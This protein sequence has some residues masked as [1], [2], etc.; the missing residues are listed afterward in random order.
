MLNSIQFIDTD[1]K[2]DEAI[3]TIQRWV[4]MGVDTETTGLDPYTSELLLLQI[5]DTENQFVFSPHKLSERIIR[6]LK[7]ILEDPN[8][9]KILHNAKFD[10]T[11]LKEKLDI[12]LSNVADTMIAEQLCRAGQDVKYG[13]DKLVD[14]YMWVDMVKTTRKYFIEKKDFEFSEEEIEYAGKDV[15]YLLPL[16]AYI[17]EIIKKKNLQKLEKLENETTLVAGDMELNGLIL[18]PVKWFALEEMAA[19]EADDLKKELNVYFEP[20]CDLSELNYNSPKQ[21]SP[22]LSKIVGKEFGST[23]KKALLN[24]E[25]E[26]VRLLLKYRE[27]FK[28]VSTYGMEFIKKYTNPI[29]KRIHPDY[30]QLRARTGRFSSD[31]PNAQNIP[32]EAKY[33][34]CFVAPKNWKVITADYKSIE[35]VIL[36]ELSQEPKFVEALEKNRDLHRMVASVLY[37]KKEEHITKDERSKGKALSFGVIYGSTAYGLASR[38]NIGRNEAQALLDTFFLKFKKVDRLLRDYVEESFENGY[39]YSPLDGR[40]NSLSTMD[41]DY[42]REMKHAMNVARNQPFQGCCASILKKAMCDIRREILSQDLRLSINASVHDELVFYTHKNEAEENKAL[43]EDSMVKA[44]EYYIKNMP[45]RVD[46]GLGDHW[47]KD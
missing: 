2:A 35:L 6:S 5:G 25:H 41:L 42:P 16:Y 18:D 33:R 8:R 40:R 47:I 4:R 9:T 32:H 37:N 39:A 3:Q 22:L 27:A 7:I 19:K 44:G 10:Y 24:E 26:A 15:G 31:N 11:F 1:E 23:G 21:I 14:K 13:L 36:A 28:L 46:V 38:L 30:N 12:T 34:A 43:V 20:F 29:T 45:V 17:Y